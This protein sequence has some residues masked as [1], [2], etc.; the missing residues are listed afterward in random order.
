MAMAVDCFTA[1][2]KGNGRASHGLMPECQMV[3]VS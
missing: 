1:E 3:S 2:R